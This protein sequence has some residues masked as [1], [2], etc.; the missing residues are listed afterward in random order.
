MSEGTMAK[1]GKESVPP[2]ASEELERLRADLR[3][4]AEQADQAL[5]YLREMLLNDIFDETALLTVTEILTASE[6]PPTT[7]FDC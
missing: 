2:T 1:G 6:P 4:R 7:C 3:A 5:T